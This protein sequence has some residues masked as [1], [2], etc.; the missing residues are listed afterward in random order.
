MPENTAYETG[1][2]VPKAAS[3]DQLQEEVSQKAAENRKPPLGIGLTEKVDQERSETDKS[4]YQDLKPTNPENDAKGQSEANHAGGRNSG[5]S[6]AD[7][8]NL[9]GKEDGDATF[10]S[11]KSE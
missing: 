6:S 2:R 3:K 1:G 9:S 10:S 7:P 5:I 4:D 11:G 8:R